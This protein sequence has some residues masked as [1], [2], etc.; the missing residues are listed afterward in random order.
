MTHLNA[1]VL[2]SRL[3]PG[4]EA[5]YE[6]EH[7]QIPDELLTLLTGEGVRDWVIWRDGAYLLHL[8]DVDDY[9]RLGE[10]LDG[11]PAN[12][13]W[14]SRMAVHVD[15]FEEPTAL[16]A[17]AAPTLVWSLQDQLAAHPRKEAP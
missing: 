13:R 5:A 9:P 12:D 7:A 2:L 4:Q 15:C 11:N 8:V 6:T 3:R 14:Q 17:L 16:P 1:T 10:R